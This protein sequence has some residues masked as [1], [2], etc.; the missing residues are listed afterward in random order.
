MQSVSNSDQNHISSAH[1]GP[2]G[3]ARKCFNVLLVC[4]RLIVTKMLLLITRDGVTLMKATF[5]CN[6]LCAES[7]AL[8]AVSAPV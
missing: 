6:A 4:H 1:L 5:A 2:G 7:T 3:D 8:Q